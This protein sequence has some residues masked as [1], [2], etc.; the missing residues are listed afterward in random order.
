MNETSTTARPTGSGEHAR[1]ERPGVRPLHRDD[2]RIA[3]QRL[4]QLA[5]A[6]VDRVD[7]G[8]AALEQDVGEAAR[9]GPDVEADEAGRVDPERVERRRR[10]CRRPA[11]RTAAASSTSSGTAAVD[12][13]AR[14][15]VARA[16]RRPSPTRTRPAMSSAW[17]RAAS[18]P[19]RARRGAGRGAARVARRRSRSCGS[20]GDHATG[21]FTAAHR[22]G[23][24][25]VR[26]ASGLAAA[27]AGVADARAAARGV[28]S[29]SRTCA[30]DP[31]RVEPD[32]PAAGR[33]PSR[34]RRTGRPGCRRS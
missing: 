12:E 19:G 7:P 4:G 17:A 1:A 16:P 27:A 25:P 14:L 32:Q 28:A 2:P 29:V 15:A 9:R 13:V 20:P 31:G 34:G 3:A 22:R 33:R 26:R 18:R 11:R 24:T 8:R 21:R 10:A 23:V 30:V 5:A 6:H